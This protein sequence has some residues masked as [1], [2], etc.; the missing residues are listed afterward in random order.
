MSDAATPFD[1]ACEAIRNGADYS[2]GGLTLTVNGIALAITDEQFDVVYDLMDEM[3]ST[4]EDV[5]SLGR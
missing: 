3:D 1:R 2:L 4:D 5:I